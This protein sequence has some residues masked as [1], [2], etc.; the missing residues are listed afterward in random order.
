VK[1]SINRNQ[2]IAEF[3]HMNRGD[4]FSNTGRSCL[5]DHIEQLESD[6]G[7]ELEFDV[8]ALCCD[9]SEIAI[10]DIKSET[11]CEDLDELRDN[12]I[13]IEVDDETIIYQVF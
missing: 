7:Q 11:G 13:V 8:I 2:F 12:T 1:Q 4:N 9:Y 6:L 10:S 3:D 5:F